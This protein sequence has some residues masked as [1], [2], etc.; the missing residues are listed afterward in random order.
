LSFIFGIFL[1][2][3]ATISQPI[4]LVFLIFGII[5][6]SVFWRRSEV[7]LPLEAG[8]KA[9]R[10]ANK[11]AVFIG[12]CLIFLF[13]GIWRRQTAELRIKND[14]LRIY[15][16]K[17]NITLIG[18]I[19]KEPDI[20]EKNVKL[21]IKPDKINGK[22]FEGKGRILATVSRYPEYQYGDKLEIIGKLET[23]PTFEGFNYKNYLKK[24]G[25]YSVI[26]NP[27][28][29]LLKRGSYAGL[30]R[31]IYAKI[32]QFKNKLRESIYQNLP[33]PQSLIL[34]A[35]ILGDKSKMPEGLKEKLNIA[36]VRHITAVSGM[37]I[38]ILSG[39]LMSLLLALGLWRGQAFYLS[40]IFIF[41]FIIMTG[42]QPSG[43]RAGIMGGI[44][45][46][47]QKIGRKF[48]NSRA[49][50]MAAALMLAINPLLLLDDAGFQLSFLAAM[51]IIY[52]A[53]IFKNWLRLFR[54]RLSLKGVA[55]FISRFLE[56]SKWLIALEEIMAMTFAAQVFTL[57][58]LVY[59]F[60]RISLA[61]PLT[62][63]LIIP[64]VYWIM[65]FGFIFSL[66]GI[67]S[68]L[69]GWLFSFPCLFLLAYLIK[70]VDFFSNPWA[71]KSFGNIHW[72]WLFVS[73]L[74]LGISVYWLN[75]KQRLKFLDY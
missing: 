47:G 50:L 5:L 51:G 17:E 62:N 9:G 44:F 37:H 68:P 18:T 14:E 65:V 60:G 75:K 56:K 73:Y 35:M 45:L 12:F 66:V 26:Y 4:E 72:P 20:R 64:V 69:F 43:I 57:P 38:V 52:L 61:A 71:A 54:R 7:P 8:L 33:P 41:L 3:I 19:V 16:S 30:T 21:A 25:I 31:A 49:I 6:I 2:S 55:E 42:A 46:L 29:K 48:V 24:Q 39:V 58:L 22:E 63:I 70:V 67:I 13:F 28:I 15:N 36:G 32:L 23:P 11:K 34:G 1:D 10:G 74:I 27:K 59:S 53:P 40:I